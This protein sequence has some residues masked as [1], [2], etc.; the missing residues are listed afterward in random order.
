V[1]ICLYNLT[2]RSFDQ[3]RT[4]KKGDAFKSQVCLFWFISLCSL[5]NRCFLVSFRGNRYHNH[6]LGILVDLW[7][8]NP[9]KTGRVETTKFITR[10]HT[11]IA[12]SLYKSILSK[13]PEIENEFEFLA[14]H[15]ECLTTGKKQK[16]VIE[17]HH[18]ER[19]FFVQKG[20]LYSYK[21]LDSGD[22]Q[23]VQ[24]AKENYWIGDLYSFISGSKALFTVETLEE[25]ELWSLTRKSWQTLMKESRAFETFF[26]ILMQTAYANLLVH[27]SDIYS[28]DAEAKY[29]RLREQ[30]PDLLQ[31]VPQYLI[32][33]YLG[34]LPSSLSRIRNKK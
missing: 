9:S 34:I 26:R 33:S 24:I 20:L 5:C 32:A 15:F 2:K 16:L 3:K 31:R 30:Y 17:G 12:E 13:V 29:N 22:I 25:C 8:Y 7:I 23:V 27:V 11:M 18:S 1:D 14:N 6:Q 10:V 28:E 21:T 19:T 4:R